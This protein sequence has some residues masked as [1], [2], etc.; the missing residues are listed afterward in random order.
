M[1]FLIFLFILKVIC[2]L[3]SLN[4]YYIKLF[5]YLCMS[6]KIIYTFTWFIKYLGV[7]I[8]NKILKFSILFIHLETF[9]CSLFVFLGEV[10]SFLILNDLYPDSDTDEKKWEYQCEVH[11][12]F[13]R[14]LSRT[15]VVELD[16]SNDT[17][18]YI[19]NFLWAV[20]LL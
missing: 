15:A 10:S 11:N 6:I 2:V 8:S 12:E 14:A 7:N 4:C 5:V 3:K 19:G 13:D 17:T 18:P 20:I 16:E 1:F 9:Y